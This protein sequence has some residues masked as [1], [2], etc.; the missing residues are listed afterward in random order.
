VKI[1]A[2]VQ[3]AGPEWGLTF[4]Y[5]GFGNKTHHKIDKGS[6]PSPTLLIDGS[7]NRVNSAAYDAN[8]NLLSAP[9][10]GTLAY[11]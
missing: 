6:G 5:D 2:A 3:A 9:L 8:G 11:L 1:P 10:G 7:T 4:I